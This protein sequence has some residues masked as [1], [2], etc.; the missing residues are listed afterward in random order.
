MTRITIA[1]AVAAAVAGGVLGGVADPVTGAVAGGLLASVG[2]G[3]ATWR[4]RRRVDRLA[5]QLA[6]WSTQDRDRRRIVAVDSSDP[7]WRRLEA[8]LDR[9]GG[10][11]DDQ[12]RR[13]Q[14]ERPWR[15]GLVDS[16]VGPALLFDGKGRLVAANAAARDLLGLPDRGPAGMSGVQ[17]LGSIALADAVTEARHRGSHVEVDAQ[18]GDR[19]VRASV[20]VVGDETLAILTDRTQQRHVEELRRDFVVNASHE[21]KTPATAIHTLAEA[22]EITVVRDP[23]R[24]P[25]LVARLREEAERL[26]HL[27]HD[28]LD[29]RRLEDRPEP[30]DTPIDLVEL[31]RDVLAELAERA[32]ARNLTLDL[33]APDR[34]DLLGTPDDLRLVLRNLVANAIQYNRDGGRV[35]VHIAPSDR[36]AWKVEVAD[37]GIGI[38]RQDLQRIFE[39]FYRVDVARSRETGGTGL[40]LSIARHAVERHHGT[41]HVDSLLGRGTTVHLTL[42]AT[43]GRSD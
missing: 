12:R 37:T 6:G 14:H 13:L 7:A 39:R 9:L 20:A 28:L 40:G 38:P 27:V 24:L 4:Q 19:H 42:P 3:V 11:L 1:V 23:E 33:H 34:A 35:D 26:V 5:R 2:V 41:I 17:A 36:G 25:D 31:A 43:P 8:A 16:L 10:Q 32:T 21:L 15:L 30:D 22:L 29:L 18:I